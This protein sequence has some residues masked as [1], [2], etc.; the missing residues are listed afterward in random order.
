MLA[1]QQEELTALRQENR[2]LAEKLTAALDGTDLCIWQGLPQTGELTVFNLQNF[3]PSEMAAHFSQ[4]LAKLHLEDRESVL[5][6]Y[7]SHLDGNTPYYEAEYR[8]FRPD[9]SITWLWDRGRVLERDADGRPLRIVGAH[10]DITRRKEY[11]TQ[12]AALAHIDP[13]TGLVNRR[14]MM[15]RLKQETEIAHREQRGFVLA[16]LDVDHFK[17]FNDTHGHETGDR[18]L[19]EVAR[20]M[21]AGLRE[22]DICARWGGE[23]F[24]LLLPSTT[25]TG[26]QTVIARLHQAIRD[27]VVEINGDT[28]CITTSIG[29]AEF[30]AGECFA[31]TLKRADT[32]LLQAKRSGRDCVLSA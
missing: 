7:F 4:W 11:E 32:A 22:Y 9:G 18:I 29:M 28:L 2:Q 23:E 26:A 31:D 20:C 3:E 12:L 24:L 1:R 27:H 15:A 5:A 21:E 8:T 25:L 6:N 16:M 13:L 17:Q 19:T 30:R 10:I 14:L